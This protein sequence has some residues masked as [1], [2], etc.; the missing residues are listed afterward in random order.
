MYHY[1]YTDICTP[2]YVCI[3]TDKYLEMTYNSIVV[4]CLKTD[5]SSDVIQKYLA[6]LLQSTFYNQNFIIKTSKFPKTGAHLFVFYPT[7]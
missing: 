4:S 3:L 6:V 1:V 5:E 7:F 2:K